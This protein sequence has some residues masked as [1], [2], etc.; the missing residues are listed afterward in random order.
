VAWRSATAFGHP[1]AL[2]ASQV[3]LHGLSDAHLIIEDGTLH[4]ATVEE[5]IFA[6][7]RSSLR[8]NET[9]PTVTNIPRPQRIERDW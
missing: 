9:V 7:G 8:N 2:I 4:V 1:A 5:E 6:I 3:I